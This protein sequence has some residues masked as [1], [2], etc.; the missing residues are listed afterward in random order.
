[1]PAPLNLNITHLTAQGR[2]EAHV[3]GLCCELDYV[4]QGQV[5]AITHTGVPPALEGRGIAARLVEAGLQ[6]AQAEGLKVRPVCS[7]VQVYL[8]R[9]PAWQALLA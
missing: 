4:L 7:Y 5:M 8:R 9:H 6:W 2:F 1:M 3:D